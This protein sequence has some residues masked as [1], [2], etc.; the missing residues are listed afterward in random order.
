MLNVILVGLEP[1]DGTVTDVSGVATPIVL[2][3]VTAPV[4]GASDKVFAPVIAESVMLELPALVLTTILP[5]RVMVPVANV[6]GLVAAV[7]VNVVVA[8]LTLKLPLV[9]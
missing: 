7:V 5:P 8:P 1:D 3:K 4:P 6:T 9:V 2:E